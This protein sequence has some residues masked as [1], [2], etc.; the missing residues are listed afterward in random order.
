MGGRRVGPQGEPQTHGPSKLGCQAQARQAHVCR[1]FAHQ[2]GHR[3]TGRMTAAHKDV[4]RAE[5]AVVHV[6]GLAII[7]Q[8]VRRD[9]GGI[10]P[11]SAVEIIHL[12]PP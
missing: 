4:L 2:G 8:A 11:R 9:R 10:Q 3:N 7:P 5:D 6:Q 12:R 1:V